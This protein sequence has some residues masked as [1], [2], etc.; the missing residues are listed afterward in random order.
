M[1]EYINECVGC[2][3]E[4]GCLGSECPHQ[5]VK[6]LYCDECGDDVDVLYDLDGQQLCIKCVAEHLPK[7]IR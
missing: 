4:I 3:K 7:I 1:I 2:P 6:Y 5:N